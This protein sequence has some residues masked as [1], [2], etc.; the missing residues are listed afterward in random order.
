M[1]SK[2]SKRDTE[3]FYRR[4]LA[5]Q[6]RSGL[7]LRAFG[8]KKGIPAGTLSHW[9]HKL[10]QRDAARRARKPQ[11]RPQFLRVKV[12]DAPR[13]GEIGAEASHPVAPAS[14]VYEVVLGPGRVLRLPR[15]FDE[16]RVAALVRAVAAC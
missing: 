9:R 2:K 10:K 15:D 6:T 7:S 13:D 16:A 11:D 8:D 1:T 12:E 5:E 14:Q 4:L 3:R